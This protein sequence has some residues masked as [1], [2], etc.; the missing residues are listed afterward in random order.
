[1]AVFTAL[2]DANVIYSAPV[3]DI[4]LEV[5]A[6][7]LFRTRWSEDIHEE[8]MRSLKENRPDISDEKIERRRRRMD[9]AFEQPLITGYEDQIT[10]LNLPDE[11]DR[12]VLAAAIVGK[13][14]VIV[15]YNIKDFPDE[16]L[17][18]FGLEVQH[19]DEFLC[20]QYTLSETL[21]LS[22]VK[23]VRQRLKSPSYDPEGYIEKLR[24]CNLEVLSSKLE[25]AAKLI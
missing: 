21:F 17:S 9:E 4:I 15:S 24:S 22:C 12:H 20:Y 23:E 7:G 2:L 14:D 11:K 18:K 19:P 25:N 3:L 6:T 13:A 5:S 8:W 16:E 10:S 1:M